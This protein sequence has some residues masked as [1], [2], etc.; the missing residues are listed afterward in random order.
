MIKLKNRTLKNK[1]VFCL[2]LSALVF[3]CDVTKADTQQK[4]A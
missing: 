1:Y 3:R 4:T 2:I